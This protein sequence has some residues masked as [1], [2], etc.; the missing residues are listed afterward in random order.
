MLFLGNFSDTAGSPRMPD[1]FLSQSFS[2]V[3]HSSPSA[4]IAP[5]ITSSFH[6]QTISLGWPTLLFAIFSTWLAIHFYHVRNNT[7]LKHIPG[8]W[9]ASCSI[10]YR[11]YYAVIKG[12]WHNDLTNLHRRYGDI[13][14]IA[15]NEVSIWDP[16]VVGEIYAYGD[17]GYPKCEMC[18]VF[19]ILCAIISYN[20]CLGMICKI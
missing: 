16:R 4:Q 6:T 14:R 15:P 12:N 7:P 8:P 19:F 20:G 9:F 13:V 2:G 3:N 10:L 5:N 11:F 18:V 17:K 1:L